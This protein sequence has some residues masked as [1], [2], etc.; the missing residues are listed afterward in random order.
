MLRT[1]S[2]DVK[3]LC[4][5]LQAAVQ[6]EAMH[7]G[8]DIEDV[9]DV[10]LEVFFEELS[11]AW[12]IL[13]HHELQQEAKVLITMETNPSERVIEHKS[14]RHNLFGEVQRADAVVL[15]VVEVQAALFQFVD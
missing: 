2:H 4:N 7:E 8:L 5:F 14:G 1:H 11:R 15:E 13:V 6:V 12:Q 10:V 9:R 3:L